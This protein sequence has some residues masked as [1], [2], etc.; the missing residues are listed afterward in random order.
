MAN[1]LNSGG[2]TITT[3][4]TPQTIYTYPNATSG[5]VQSIR[6]ANISGGA[7]T[8]D[9]QLG[10]KYL[11]KSA[12]LPVGASDEQ[13]VSGPLTIKQSE[14]I[15]VTCNTSAALSAFYSVIERS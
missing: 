1:T 5:L 3:L 9:V 6:L 7:I 15:V 8:Y 13:I 10:T 11:I 4:N 12:P 14:T 2:A